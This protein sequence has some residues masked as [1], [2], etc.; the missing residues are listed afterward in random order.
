MT[1]VHKDPFDI[2]E[3]KEYTSEDVD[4]L[5]YTASAVLSYASVADHGEFSEQAEYWCKGLEYALSKFEDRND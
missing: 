3:D 2:S 1:W 4:L 5:I